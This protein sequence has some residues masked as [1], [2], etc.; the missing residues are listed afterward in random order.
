MTKTAVLPQI[1][2]LDVDTLEIMLE[3]FETQDEMEEAFAYIV[4]Q[5]KKSGGACS[6]A[7]E[8]YE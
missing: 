4:E 3:H 1:D 5:F 7:E 6:V 8:S 2:D